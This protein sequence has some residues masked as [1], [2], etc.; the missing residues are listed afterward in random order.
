MRVKP[1]DRVRMIGVMP[2]DPD[3][4]PIGME[5]TVEEVLPE[6]G[7]IWVDWDPDNQGR[8]RSLILLTNDP[9]QVIG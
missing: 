4:I 6:V 2:N 1:G 9:F 7:Q 3:P 5:G 8:Q